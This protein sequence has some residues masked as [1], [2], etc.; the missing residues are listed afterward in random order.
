MTTALLLTASLG[1]IAV[2]VW[3]VATDV[4]IGRP[5]RATLRRLQSY[6]RRSV[7]T[8][9]GRRGADNGSQNP[10]KPGCLPRA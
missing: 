9:P 1:C 8:A 5:E 2:A 4:V 6:G 3:L 10:K 7:A